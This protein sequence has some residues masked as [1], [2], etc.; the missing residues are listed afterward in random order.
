MSRSRF[1]D[2]HS[3]RQP[4]VRDRRPAGARRLGGST[5]AKRKSPTASGGD[6]Q[7]FRSHARLLP[8][9]APILLRPPPP[10]LNAR[11]SK[12][13]P[14]PS[15][16]TPTAPHCRSPLSQLLHPPHPARLG[17]NRPARRLISATAA[18]ATAAAIAL[19]CAVSRNVMLASRRSSTRTWCADFFSSS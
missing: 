7:V 10:P 18:A 12:S 5:L 16:P 3:H 14:C 6:A 17:S 1:S 2:R 4:R 8:P 11:P 13:P 19:S 9:L 15:S